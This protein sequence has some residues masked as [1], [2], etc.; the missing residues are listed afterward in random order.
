AAATVLPGPA[1]DDGRQRVEVR[2]A[3]PQRAISPG[4]SVVFYQG[5]LVVGGGVIARTSRG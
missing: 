1:G 2:F 4:Q 3:T 5:D